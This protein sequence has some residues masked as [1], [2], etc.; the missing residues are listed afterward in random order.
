MKKDK[1]KVMSLKERIMTDKRLQDVVGFGAASVVF[2]I[3]FVASVLNGATELAIV[4]GIIASFMLVVFIS[5]LNN[6]S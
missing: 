3:L 6:K 5:A 2:V 1:T 4:F